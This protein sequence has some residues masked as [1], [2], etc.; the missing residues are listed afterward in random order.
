MVLVRLNPSIAD[1]VQES[2]LLE[3]PPCKDWTPVNINQK[4]LRIVAMVSGR[5]FVGP[6]L[7][8]SEEYLDA[9][10]NYT[11]DLM[12]AQRA[13]NSLAPWKR[14][15]LGNRLPQVKKLDQRLAEATAFLRP[16]VEARQKLP[17]E[18]RPDDMLQ[19]LMTAQPKFGEHTAAKMAEL[20]LN[21]SFAAIH[22]TTLTST[23]V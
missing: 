3:M 19:W 2:L 14:P 7:C 16:V 11:I 8:R 23:N 21:I 13:V 20:Q 6:E 5:V 18:E 12:A 1:E 22:T 4:L 10:I 15:F 17:V 9:A